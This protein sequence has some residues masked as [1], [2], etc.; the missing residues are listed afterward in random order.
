RMLEIVRSDQ[1]A[2]AVRLEAARALGA[3]RREGLEPDAERLVDSR[4]V[5]LRLA[6]A[7]LVASHRSK[8]AARLLLRLT[9]DPEPGV[10]APAAGTVVEIDPDL[11]LSS[12]ARLLRSSDANV[13]SVAVEGLLRRPTEPHLALLADRLDDDHPG[14]REKARRA[15]KE[16]AAKAELRERIIDQATRGVA[17]QGWGG[18]EQAAVVVAQPAPQPPA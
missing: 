1:S 18:R 17:G 15:M 14:V 5:A 10:V 9:E 2:A 7:S 16:L 8:E 13:R 12:V 3:L 11:L 4:N 6:A